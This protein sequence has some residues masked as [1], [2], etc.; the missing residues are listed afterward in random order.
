MSWYTCQAVSAQVDES[1]C[2]EK[3]IRPLAI[4]TIVLDSMVVTHEGNEPATYG[5]ILRAVESGLSLGRG[6]RAKQRP[7]YLEDYVREV[8]GLGVAVFWEYFLLSVKGW[9]REESIIP[10]FFVCHFRV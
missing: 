7:K 3:G 4:T 5:L 9:I 10:S 6:N 2:V 1:R 8:K